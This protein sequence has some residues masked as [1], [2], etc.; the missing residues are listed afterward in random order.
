[1]DILIRMS[2]QLFVGTILTSQ[3]YIFKTLVQNLIS[4]FHSSC[5]CFHYN[6]C[7]KHKIYCNMKW[8]HSV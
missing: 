5:T 7:F 8:E 1:M 6:H 4:C 3:V 2:Y